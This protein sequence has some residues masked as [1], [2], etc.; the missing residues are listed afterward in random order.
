MNDAGNL[1]PIADR[2]IVAAKGGIIIGRMQNVTILPIYNRHNHIVVVDI[3][4]RYLVEISNRV[5]VALGIFLPS[6]NVPENAPENEQPNDEPDSEPDI[7]A[8]PRSPLAR[9]GQNQWKM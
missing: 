9:G 5:A 7:R 2:M 4:T 3:A 8:L 6:S 1:V